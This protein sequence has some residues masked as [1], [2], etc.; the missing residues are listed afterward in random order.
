[1]ALRNH[2]H[3]HGGGFHS[4]F[5]P[6]PL[7]NHPPGHRLQRDL[8]FFEQRDLCSPTAL[9]QKHWWAQQHAQAPGEWDPHQRRSK[10]TVDANDSSTEQRWVEE[11]ASSKGV[12]A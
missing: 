4:D 1:M 2:R 10:R 12:E 11:E 8:T 6:F 7:R 9:Q 5:S 3:H